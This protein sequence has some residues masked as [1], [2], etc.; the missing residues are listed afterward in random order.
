MDRGVLGYSSHL[1]TEDGTGAAGGR[2]PG[3]DSS[4]HERDH[5]P[6]TGHLYYN[7][8]YY[9]ESVLTFGTV[10]PWSSSEPG[11]EHDLQLNDTYFNS[12]TSFSGLP[13]GYDDCPTAG[14]ADPAGTKIFSFG[15]FDADRI[16][17]NTSYWGYWQFSGGTGSSTF[18]N[19]YGQEVYHQFCFWDGIWCMGSVPNHTHL[20]R[21]GTL[22]WGQSFTHVWP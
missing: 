11:Y 20:L 22:N 13:N 3:D 18:Y 9:A 14:A 8:A 16:Q 7:G 5:V 19:L 4:V 1:C 6:V 15:S 2:P 17:A 12:C 10:G 21:G